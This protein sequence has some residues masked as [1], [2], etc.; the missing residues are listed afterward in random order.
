MHWGCGA[1]SLSQTTL[2]EHFGTGHILVSRDA[3]RAEV[4]DFVVPWDPRN[5][6]KRDGRDRDP[7]CLRRTYSLDVEPDACV[8]TASYDELI[9]IRRSC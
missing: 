1:L 2:E 8:N 3:Q 9:A 4:H 5:G 6:I 7:L